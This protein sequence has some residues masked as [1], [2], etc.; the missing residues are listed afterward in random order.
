MRLLTLSIIGATALLL[1]L[2][3]AKDAKETPKN[4]SAEKAGPA[5]AQSEVSLVV[6]G[7]T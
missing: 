4:K 7:M 2:A 5:A 3:Q 1:T 6:K